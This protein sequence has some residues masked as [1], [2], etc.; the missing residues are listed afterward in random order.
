MHY[1]YSHSLR[2]GGFAAFVAE[3]FTYAE[4]KP[5]GGAHY[6]LPRFLQNPELRLNPLIRDNHVHDIYG[7]A[8]VFLAL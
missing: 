3:V 2:R 6:P 8:E 7:V 5:T 4:Y 1:R